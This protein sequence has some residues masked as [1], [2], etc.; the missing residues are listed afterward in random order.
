MI[1]AWTILTAV[2]NRLTGKRST[3]Q[4]E[5]VTDDTDHGA[6]IGKEAVMFEEFI[7]P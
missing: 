7:T 2:I 3:E 1:Y 5:T 6:Q 4:G